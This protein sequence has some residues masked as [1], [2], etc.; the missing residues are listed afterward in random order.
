MK[1]QVLQEEL[2]KALATSIRF[3]NTRNTLPILGNFLLKSGKTKLEVEATNLEMSISISLGAKVEEEGSLTVPA[4]VFQEL[5]ANLVRGSLTLNQNKQELKIEGEGFTGTIPAM[6]D[7]DFP[8]IPQAGKLDKTFQIKVENLEKALSKVLFSASLDETRPVLTGVLF[9]FEE[10]GL[11]LVSS[12]G[13]RLSKKTIKL[14][15]KIESKNLIIPRNSLVELL[16]NMG[17]LEKSDQVLFSVK[18][19]ENQLVIKIGD[20][21][22]ATRL[23]DGNFPDFEKIIPK[24]LGTKVIVDKTDLAR[25]VKLASVFARESANVIK[26]S[27]GHSSANEAGS[28]IITSESQKG[29][30]QK[31]SIEATVTGPYVDISFNYKYIEDFLNVSQANDLEINLNDSISPAIFVDPV[32][33]DFLHLIMP[34]RVQ[35]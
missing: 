23:I 30:N 9:I 1:I 31:G 20:I 15:K 32:D 17:S 27:I 19:N 34:V 22:L 6:E 14:N 25:L 28:L 13:F 29:G 18:E 21:Y 3:I 4:K 8:S 35:N 10:T 16:R 2:S 33:K 5:I 26:L 12:D 7:N 24:N 11:S